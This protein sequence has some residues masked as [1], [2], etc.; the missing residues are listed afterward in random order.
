M[1]IYNSPQG[2][3][4]WLKER[5]GHFTASKAN[6]LLMPVSNLGYKDLIYQIAIEK[7]TGIP[8]DINYKSYDMIRGNEL[9]PQAREQYQLETFDL[10]KEVGFM[11]LNEFVGMSSDGLIGDDR[12]LEIKCKKYNTHCRLLDG[13]ELM[14]KKDFLQI[15]F[16][17]FVSGRKLCVYYCYYPG[18]KSYVQ[19]IKRDEKTISEIENKLE[20]AIKHVKDRIELIKKE[21]S[22]AK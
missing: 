21:Q 2:S 6:E 13:T 8:I 5:A 18:I 7:I 17:L 9:E 22:D 14:P 11:E 15:Q 1:K 4:S 12:Q 3:E 19:K 20:V 10:V 16:Q